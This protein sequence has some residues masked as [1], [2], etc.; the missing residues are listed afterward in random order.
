MRTAGSQGRI[1]LRL[2]GTYFELTD[3]IADRRPVDRPAGRPEGSGNPGPALATAPAAASAGRREPGEERSEL[4]ISVA[5]RLVKSA[6]RRNTVKRIVREAWRAATDECIAKQRSQ[7]DGQPAGGQRHDD[8]AL[9]AAV[10]G[11][12]VGSAVADPALGRP[13]RPVRTCLVRLKRSPWAESDPSPSFTMIKRNLRRDADRLF[14]T[15][16]AK[17]K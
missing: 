4:L 12:A 8:G 6:V 11:N 13:T 14:A 16:Q 10:V 3:R 15:Y 7:A 17:R 5:K 9:P 1:R 2:T